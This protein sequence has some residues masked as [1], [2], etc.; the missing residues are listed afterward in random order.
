[1]IP[2]SGQSNLDICFQ[3]KSFYNKQDPNTIYKSS[4]LPRFNY[5]RLYTNPDIQSY[6]RVSTLIKARFPSITVKFV[7]GNYYAFLQNAISSNSKGTQYLQ[8]GDQSGTLRN[9][10]VLLDP[11]D[12]GAAYISVDGK[13]YNSLNQVD[14]DVKLNRLVSITFERPDPMFGKGGNGRVNITTL[15]NKDN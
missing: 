4:K 14:Q 12:I 7:R 1:M 9:T 13:L 15:D 3:K 8:G 2:L 5:S 6:G 10:I 11:N